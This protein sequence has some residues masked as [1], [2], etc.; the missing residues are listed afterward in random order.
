MEYGVLL[1]PMDAQPM[2]DEIWS[3]LVVISGLHPLISPSILQLGFYE[4]VNFRKAL[5]IV[6][7]KLITLTNSVP[8]LHVFG[9]F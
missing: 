2:F 1:T 5:K 9:L 3:A 7:L 4:V 6:N 8:F